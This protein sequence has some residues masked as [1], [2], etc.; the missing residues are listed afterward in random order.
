[1][2]QHFVPRAYLKKFAAKERGHYFVDVYDKKEER[3][4]KANIKN[5]C[6]EIDIYTLSEQNSFTKDLL[7]IEKIYANGIEPLYTKAYDVLTNHN[8]F[9]ISP[10]M[11]AEIIIAVFQFYIRN[12][13]V[14]KRSLAHHKEEILKHCKIAKENGSK[15]VT[16][17]EED[18]SFRE[19]SELDII[20]FFEKK[21]TDEFKEKHI[22][23]LGEISN[24]HEHAIFE[25]NVINDESEFITSDHPLVLQDYVRFDD[26]PLYKSKTFILPIN[27]KT[28]LILYHDNNKSTGQIY[29]CFIPNLSVATINKLIIEQ[30][31]R[32]VIA[33]KNVLD[34]HFQ[35]CA[36][37]LDNTDVK[38]KIDSMKQIIE[39]FGKTEENKE[40]MEIMK[41]YL[42]KYEIDGTLTDQE[43]YELIIKLRSIQ[44]EFIKKRIH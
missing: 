40:A 2:N 18:F 22:G 1:M 19:F 3:F 28:A 15:G 29:R 6:S 37:Y 24:F 9:T 34:R 14:L 16:Y 21:V 31:T 44:A 17:L 27:K 42:N 5:I 23:G 26:H 41:R 13:R 8:A 33:D 30:S 36:D 39:K 43:Q 25:V 11:R 32:F 12:P 38:L 35:L 4:F 7:I 10:I 20:N